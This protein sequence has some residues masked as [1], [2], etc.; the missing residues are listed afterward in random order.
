MVNNKLTST[1]LT[2]SI[3]INAV[4]RHFDWSRNKVFANCIIWRWELDIAIVTPALFLTEVEI[5][6]NRPDWL[7]DEKKD[8]F[9]CP[10]LIQLRENHVANFYYAV[11]ENIAENI[12]DFVASETGILVIKD[13]EKLNRYG[14]SHYIQV[15]RKAKKKNV[16]ITDKHFIRLMNLSYSKYW[17]SRMLKEE[18]ILKEVSKK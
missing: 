2:E 18:N 6:L 11:P 1:K 13:V 12:P 14:V 17:L 3:A 7:A 10:R 15:L 9:H 4:A 5:K 16:R 8:K